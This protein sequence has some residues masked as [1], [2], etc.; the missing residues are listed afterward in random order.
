MQVRPRTK[1]PNEVREPERRRPAVTEADLKRIE[2]RLGITLPKAYR[3]LMSTRAEELKGLTYEI[4][5]IT[6]RWFDNV[7]Y[8]DANRV[9]AANL[10]ERQPDAGTEYAFPDW[11]K[12]F[13]LIGTNGAGDYYCLRLQGDRKVWMIGSD[14]GDKP[15]EMYESLA[16]FVAEQVR[17]HAREQPWQPPPVF[18]SFDDSCPLLERFQIFLGREACEIVCQEGDCPL[19]EEKLRRHGI[20]VGE[21]GRVVLRLVATLARCDPAVLSIAVNPQ[22]SS[23][24]S[25]MLNFGRP[26]LGD[27]RWR[28]VGARIFGGTVGVSLFGPPDKAPPPGKVGIN[29]TAFQKAVRDLLRLLHPAG[30]RVT[31]SKVCLRPSGRLGEWNYRLAYSLKE[32]AS[33]ARRGT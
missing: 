4:R 33:R 31:V 1:R 9:I 29:W 17:R 23:S 18:S 13:F 20:D 30:T 8:L 25:L 26:S 10:A 21:L 22:P 16:A 15:N 14:C 6:H 12:T 3:E 11:S 32:K 2:R 19:T 27:P 28:G 5:G 24:G 7:L